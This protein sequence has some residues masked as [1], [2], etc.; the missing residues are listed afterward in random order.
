MEMISDREV[1]VLYNKENLILQW[2]LE[3]GRFLEIP[4]LYMED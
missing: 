3:T 4:N 1:I 2:N